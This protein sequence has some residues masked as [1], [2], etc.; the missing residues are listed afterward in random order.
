MKEKLTVNAIDRALTILELVG[1]SKKGLTNGEISRKIKIP[2]STASYIL[3]TLKQRGYLHRDDALGKYRISAKLFSVGSQALRGLELH[4]VAYP[5]LQDVV[6]KTGLAG[7]L[8]I[9]DGHEAVYIEKIDKPGFIRMNTWVGRR[10]DV[11]CTSVGKALIA[12]LPQEIVE[13]IVRD[14]GLPKRTPKTITTLGHLLRELAQVR[15]QGYATDD[16]E[17]NLDVVCIA[18]PIFNMEGRTVAAVGLTGTES[19][20]RSHKYESHVKL[21]KHAARQ[22]SHQLGFAGAGHHP[23]HAERLAPAS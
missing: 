2:K 11:H 21:I 16:S 20:M 17:N 15:A 18:A 4:D 10:M 9:L 7:H 14:R 22:M 8:A 12:H 1:H 23:G 5:L 6:E 13:E 19:Q 3:R